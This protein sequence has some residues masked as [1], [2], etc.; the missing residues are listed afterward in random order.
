MHKLRELHQGKSEYQQQ[1]AVS[2]RMITDI[3]MNGT[4]RGAVEEFHL[5]TNLHEYDALFAECIRS[6]PTVSIDAQNWLYRLTLET[7]KVSDML[8][9]AMVPPAKKPQVRSRKTIPHMDIYGFRAL[10]TPFG[11]LSAF[12]F[13]RYWTAEALGPP[14]SLDART[15]TTWTEAGRQLLG[16]PSLKDGTAKSLTRRWK[17]RTLGCSRTRFYATIGHLCDCDDHMY[18][19]YKILRSRMPPSLQPIVPNISPCSFG[20]GLSNPTMPAFRTFAC[21]DYSIST[22]TP[23]T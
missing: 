9:T 7:E 14:S 5:C 11:N 21:W 4:I 23:L 22:I 6:F 13:L 20:P 3:E 10:N 18:P 1:R 2:G 12:E 17:G 8:V 19:Y 16:T 15:R